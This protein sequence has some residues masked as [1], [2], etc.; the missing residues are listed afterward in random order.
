MGRCEW[1]LCGTRMDLHSHK[2]LRL[3]IRVAYLTSWTPLGDYRSAS[4][5]TK[6]KQARL[7]AQLPKHVAMH[8]GTPSFLIRRHSSV[9]TGDRLGRGVC[10]DL[11]PLP[12]VANCKNH[13]DRKSTG[14][15]DSSNCKPNFP[16]TTQ[17]NQV[18][19]AKWDWH[20][21][22]LFWIMQSCSCLQM[23]ARNK[24]GAHRPVVHTP[25]WVKCCHSPE[26]NRRQGAT[27]LS[28]GLFLWVDEP[29]TS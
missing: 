20:T 24:P 22:L 26:W 15:C 10:S 14:K 13:P 12:G 29:V 9:A 1:K 23:L 28:F 21:A 8:K 7:G 4:V 19:P 16:E 3:Q 18:V 27:S 11:A 17:S 6:D 2:T 25:T 5:Y